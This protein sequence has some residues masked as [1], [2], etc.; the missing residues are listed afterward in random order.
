VCGQIPAWAR[1]QTLAAA[2]E[3]QFN[4]SS[5]GWVDPDAIF[6]EVVTC[7]LEL[8]FNKVRL[9]RIHG[10][11]HTLFSRAAHCDRTLGCVVVIACG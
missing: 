6:P 10:Q 1:G 8:I 5:G 4:T 9:M 3:R 7:N 11:C 2:L